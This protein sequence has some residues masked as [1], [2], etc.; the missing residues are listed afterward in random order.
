MTKSIAL[1]VA[2]AFAVMAQLAIAVKRAE[3]HARCAAFE[4]S[5]RHLRG[6]VVRVAGEELGFAVLDASE[7][8]IAVE[9]GFEQ[10]RVAGWRPLLERCE[11]RS[12][13]SR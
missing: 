7:D 10:P 8:A 5:A 4:L 11:L 6:P 13:L 1:V 3:A 9:L 12:E 2:G